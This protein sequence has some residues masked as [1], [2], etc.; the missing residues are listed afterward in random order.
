MAN[1]LNSATELA[2]L[3]Q[4]ATCLWVG[5]FLLSLYSA[6]YCTNPFSSTFDH[7]LGLIVSFTNVIKW[8]KKSVIKC[9]CTKHNSK[10]RSN[11]KVHAQNGK[12]KHLLF[13]LALHL[14][15][16]FSLN[17]TSNFLTVQLFVR[18]FQAYHLLVHQSFFSNFSPS[19]EFFKLRYI[20][21]SKQ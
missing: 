2:H 19:L 20:L 5:Q 6:T 7:S 4:K 8:K 14:R 15:T 10:K 12:N 16:R 21:T 17:W 11:G 3:S 9:I 13:L 1:P 18:V